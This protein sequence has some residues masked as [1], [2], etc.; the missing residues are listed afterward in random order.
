M[1]VS[2]RLQTWPLNMIH[3]Q[4]LTGDHENF[5]GDYE[6]LTGVFGRGL[7]LGVSHGFQTGHSP[8]HIGSV[9]DSKLHFLTSEIFYIFLPLIERS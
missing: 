4:D 1:C 8:V 3:I 5:A 2:D 9:T 6:D 7:I